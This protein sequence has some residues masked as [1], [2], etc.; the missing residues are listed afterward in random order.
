MNTDSLRGALDR[1]VWRGGGAPR[2]DLDN[3]DFRDA[4]E[5]HPS[6]TLVCLLCTE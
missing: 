4:L 3:P 1:I 2:H 5:T 6:V